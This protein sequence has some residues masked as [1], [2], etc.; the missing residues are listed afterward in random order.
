MQAVACRAQLIVSHN[1]SQCI[2]V[3]AGEKVQLGP[4]QQSCIPEGSCVSGEN[5][6]RMQHCKGKV[7]CWVLFFF[8]K[9]S[10]KYQVLTSCKTDK[11][12]NNSNTDLVGKKIRTKA[13]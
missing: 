5:Q 8:S 3:Q 4:L 2:L 12:S 13:G 1:R 6:A 10:E 11:N 7:L 9:K